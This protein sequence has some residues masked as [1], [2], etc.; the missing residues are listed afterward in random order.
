[1]TAL[2]RIETQAVYKRMFAVEPDL[3]AILTVAATQPPE[4]ERWKAYCVLKRLCE[5]LVGFSARHPEL[6]TPAHYEA[7]LCAIDEL[8]PLVSEVALIGEDV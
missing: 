8:L 6:R 5:P 1:M 4:R 2:Q 7:M 3:Y